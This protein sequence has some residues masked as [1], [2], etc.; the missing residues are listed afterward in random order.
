MFRPTLLKIA[1][2]CN[3]SR[4]LSL[5]SGEAKY[6]VFIKHYVCSAMKRMRY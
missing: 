2:E 3:R 4:H 5:I 1:K 6:D